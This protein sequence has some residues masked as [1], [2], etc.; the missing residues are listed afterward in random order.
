M[1]QSIKYLF[2]IFL[3]IICALCF[4]F[5]LTEAIIGNN[6]YKNM[7]WMFATF[8]LFGCVLY[9]NQKFTNKLTKF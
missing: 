4:L 6:P 9:L 3:N 8:V 1:K 5:T 7:L 2:V